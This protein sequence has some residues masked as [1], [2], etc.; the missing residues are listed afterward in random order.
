MRSPENRIL[1]AAGGVFTRDGAT[2]E[3]GPP[4]EEPIMLLEDKVAV[5]YGA[6]GNVGRAMAR[7]FARE[8][9]RVFLT[10]RTL[11]TVEAVAREIVSDG[12][13][14]EAAEVDA[15]EEK[16]IERHLDT[17]LAQAGGLDV[18][19]NESGIP[20]PGIQGIP[21]VDL[22]LEAFMRPVEHYL[23]SSFL[24]ARAAARRMRGPGVIL[25][26]TPEPAR[27]GLPLVGGM[28]PAWASME[29]L[30]RS[31]SAE[32]AA[33]GIR[34]VCLRSSG[35]P[36]TSTIDVVFDLHARALGIARQDFLKLVESRSHRQRSTSL[37]ELTG[38]AVFLASDAAAGITG[39][40]INLT[41]GLTA[42]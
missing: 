31:L 4:D 30:T 38:A 34:A 25:M 3:S 24:T 27:I 13:R 6:A 19:V 35:I 28:G 33:R 40:V 8:G 37:A 7:A 10:G 9:A 1:P 18:S 12:G 14:A 26:H 29:A 32:L 11:R 16:A 17:V 2:N 41:G 22:P 36:E 23:R 20:Q 21:L 5:I 15:T 42:D 39:T